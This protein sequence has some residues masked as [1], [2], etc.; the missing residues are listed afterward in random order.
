MVAAV[1]ADDVR[2][3]AALLNAGA[4][5]NARNERGETAFSFACANNSLAA[6]KL[7]FARGADVNTT[8]CGWRVAVG[9]G[10]VLVIAG[11]PGVARRRRRPKA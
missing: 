6:A 7:L 9:L 5:V 3:I 4:A 2:R 11:V 1:C 10:G 8:R